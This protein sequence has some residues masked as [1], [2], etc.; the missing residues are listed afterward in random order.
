MRKM[1]L[2][3]I[4]MAMVLVFGGQK[5]Y[6]M[7]YAHTACVTTHQTIINSPCSLYRVTVTNSSAANNTM[8]LI[9]GGETKAR[10][11]IPAK[12]GYSFKLECRVATNL[13]V[14]LGSADMF[15]GVE[16]TGTTAQGWYW[17][18]VIDTDVIDTACGAVTDLMGVIISNNDGN[19][20]AI[21]G[22]FDYGNSVMYF[23]CPSLQTK[24]YQVEQVNYTT[25]LNVKNPHAG[26]CVTTIR[27]R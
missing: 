10:W 25:A 8:Y 24:Y 12:D 21:V 15:V 7:S 17:D 4:V 27:R 13:T 3:F 11:V 19:T 5:A 14:K 23:A 22:L 16:Y 2:F 18:A 1:I 6:S 20:G 9:D 26:V